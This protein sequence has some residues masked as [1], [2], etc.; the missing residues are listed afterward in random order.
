MKIEEYS[1]IELQEIMDKS[2]SYSDVLRSIGLSVNSSNMRSLHLIIDKYKLSEDKLNNNRNKNPIYFNKVNKAKSIDD[3]L[4][5]GKNINTYKLKNKLYKCGLKEEK[6]ELCGITE[7]NGKKISFQLHHVDGNREN[8]ELSN[9]MILCPNCH[10]QTD[11]YAGKKA[12]KNQNKCLICGCEISRSGTHCRECYFKYVKQNNLPVNR[13]ELKSLIRNTPF[14][15]IGKMFGVSDNAIRKW[16]N[17]YN[18]PKKSTEIK[19]YSNEE[20]KNI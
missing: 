11:N 18:L 3:I 9:L 20:W 17:K 4:I 10:S 13:E 2:Y 7:W 12:K 15:S 5:N 14:T 6:C 8:N 16:C 1:K 19:K